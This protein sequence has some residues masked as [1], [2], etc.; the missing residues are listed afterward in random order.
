MFGFLKMKD[1]VFAFLLRENE[2]PLSVSF[3]TDVISFVRGVPYDY[4][5]RSSFRTEAVTYG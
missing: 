4:V 5:K 3:Y 2:Y 1:D